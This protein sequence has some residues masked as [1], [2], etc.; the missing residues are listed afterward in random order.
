MRSRHSEKGPPLRIQFDEDD[1]GFTVIAGKL[2]SVPEGW[3]EVRLGHFEPQWPE[4]RLRGLSKRVTKGVPIITIHCHRLSSIVD[5]DACV[6]CPAAQPRGQKLTKELL[7]QELTVRE[8][9]EELTRM[10]PDLAN[11]DVEPSAPEPILIERSTKRT[12]PRKRVEKADFQWPLCIYRVISD[13]EGCCPKLQ[14][15]CPDHLKS[16]KILKRKDCKE[17][18]KR[19]PA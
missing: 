19:K 10:T 6:G 9:H 13:E 11:N 5:F 7:E 1:G 14:C 16:G 18:D 2:V 12:D 4:C 15:T 8:Y 17:C 3:K